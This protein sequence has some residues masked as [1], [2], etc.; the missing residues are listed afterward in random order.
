MWQ[1][2]TLPVRNYNT[3]VP[4]AANNAV[5]NTKTKL[6]FVPLLFYFFRLSIRMLSLK[7]SII[8]IYNHFIFIYNLKYKNSFGKS[9]I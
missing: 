6:L 3:G 9:F 2:Q 4:P 1:A 8:I 5:I 7:F